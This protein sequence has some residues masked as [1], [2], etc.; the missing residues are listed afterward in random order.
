VK[1]AILAIL[2]F[3]FAWLLCYGA[4]RT[5]EKIAETQTSTELE[6]LK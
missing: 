1:L 3:G 4:M 6:A 2:S 5:A